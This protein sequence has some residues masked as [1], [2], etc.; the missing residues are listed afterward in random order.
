MLTA[1]G[2]A[3]GLADALAF[4]AGDRNR[5]A[6]AGAAARQR[7]TTDFGMEALADR[8]EGLIAK[9]CRPQPAGRS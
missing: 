3:A 9:A 7:V 2:D 5:L 6:T 8:L 4:L 1:P